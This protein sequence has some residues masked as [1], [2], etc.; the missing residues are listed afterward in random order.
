MNERLDEAYERYGVVAAELQRG[1]IDYFHAQKLFQSPIEVAMAE[2]LLIME[3]GYGWEFD[4]LIDVFEDFRDGDRVIVQIVPQKA[5]GPYKVDLAVRVRD[6]NDQ[7]HFIAVE[8]DGHDFHEKTK[9][10]A[11]HDKKRDRYLQSQ[12]YKVYRFAGSEIFADPKK[13]ADEVGQAVSDAVWKRK[14]A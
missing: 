4:G 7:Y 11:A 3:T 13:C 14:R 6:A 9:L 12:G 8:C 5:V 10:Q 1:K 2:A